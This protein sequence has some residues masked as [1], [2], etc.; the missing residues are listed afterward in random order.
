MNSYFVRFLGKI[1]QVRTVLL[2][3]RFPEVD[4]L[5]DAL[6]KP[7][8]SAY[9]RK[10]IACSHLSANPV[11]VSG[12]V[13][14]DI[15]FDVELISRHNAKAILFDPTPR[16][17]THIA[18]VSRRYGLPNQ[19]EYSDTGKQDAS[20]YN[21]ISVNAG[22]LVLHAFA[23]LEEAK[24]VKFFEPPLSDHV[25]YSI[26]NI[27]NHF[28]SLGA[29]IEVEAIGPKEVLGLI[30]L[31]DIEVLKLDI[32]G[33][34]FAFLDSCFRKE[35]YPAQILVEIDE[36]HFPSFRSRKIARKLFRLFNKNNY[37]LVYRDGYNFTYL[38]E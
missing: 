21:L 28:K 18:E 13:G 24:L 3:P 5:R 6:I 16:A 1:Q 15:S 22:N 12:G 36:L 7:M 8:G 31:M 33:S 20:N 2:T 34:E 32:E 19:N 37:S 4:S 25:S 9:G 30:S 26:Q 23:L 29:H 17:I 35:I 10:Y 11:L 27:Q 14:E 38:R